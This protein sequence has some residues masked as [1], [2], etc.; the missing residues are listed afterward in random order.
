M[1]VDLAVP[2]ED[3]DSWVTGMNGRLGQIWHCSIWGGCG[4]LYEGIMGAPGWI[5]GW[6]RCGWV[7]GKVE[8]TQLNSW[9]E[10]EVGIEVPWSRKHQH[11]ITACLLTYQTYRDDTLGFFSF[12]YV[13]FLSHFHNFRA[14]F[15]KNVEFCSKFVVSGKNSKLLIIS[16]WFSTQVIFKTINTHMIAWL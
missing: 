6:D 4:I 12:N 3:C 5:K 15:N 8:E 13:N 2:E 7:L 16:Y 14:F 9:D 11:R 1:G 10:Y